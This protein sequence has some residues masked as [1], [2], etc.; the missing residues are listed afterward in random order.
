MQAGN[1]D[2]TRNAFLESLAGKN[3]AK[4]A[5]AAVIAGTATQAVST[6]DMTMDEYKQ[7]IYD[8][9]SRLPMDPSRRWDNISIHISDDGFEAMKNDPEYEEWVMDY[10]RQDFM[11]YNPWT[12]VC[13]GCYCV[14][15]IG[16]SPEEYHGESWYTGYQNGKA[17]S[18]YQ[19]KSQEN[20]WEQRAE[21]AERLQEQYEKF[22]DKKALAMRWQKEQMDAEYVAKKAEGASDADAADAA[23][24][25]SQ[26]V[27]A[28][29]ASMILG[30]M[31][32][33]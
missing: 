9:I 30:I 25:I 16:A 22:L 28:F 21:R 23:G 1:E 8:R 7:Y 14:K 31:A 17:E 24:Q 33:K 10:L 19:K 26:I 12:A 13:G 2:S 11:S 20:F 5:A 32:R 15:Y 3:A 27:T 29:D 6:Q 18:L 4:T